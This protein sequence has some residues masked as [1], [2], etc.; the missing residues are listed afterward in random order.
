MDSS[1][2]VVN[3][4]GV[5][6][7]NSIHSKY[8]WEN[9]NHLIP[10]DGGRKYPA[11]LMTIPDDRGGI[12]VLYEAKMQH[13]PKYISYLGVLKIEFSRQTTCPPTS[14]NEARDKLFERKFSAE[15]LQV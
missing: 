10:G 5:K 8:E 4:I 2:R 12:C 7:G 9:I 14:T 3:G 6:D 13:L 1:K 15:A 11:I